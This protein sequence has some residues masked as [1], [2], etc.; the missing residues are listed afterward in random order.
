[1]PSIM[2]KSW[3]KNPNKYGKAEMEGKTENEVE[4]I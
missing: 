1:M 4:Y 3:L 2:A